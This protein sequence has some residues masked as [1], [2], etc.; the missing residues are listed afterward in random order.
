[1]DFKHPHIG[2]VAITRLVDLFEIGSL[3]TGL[4][5]LTDPASV[6]NQ[7]PRKPTEKG[8]CRRNAANL[9]LLVGLIS[10]RPAYT[11]VLTHSKELGFF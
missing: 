10:Y 5:P 4:R 9:E 1:M 11:N 8:P 3:V 6:A 7:L 2:R